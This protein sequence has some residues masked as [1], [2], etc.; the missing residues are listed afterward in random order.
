MTVSDVV[1]L[2]R[3]AKFITITQTG[4]SQQQTKMYTSHIVSYMIFLACLHT[5]K[6]KLIF[7]LNG[8]YKNYLCK[9]QVKNFRSSKLSAETSLKLC[10]LMDCFV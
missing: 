4:A 7:M 8:N 1:T 6:P 10:K 5:F 2:Q 9:R 3:M